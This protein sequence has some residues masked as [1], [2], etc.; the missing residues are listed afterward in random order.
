[1]VLDTARSAGSAIGEAVGLIKPKKARLV[2]V[3]DI[4][5]KDSDDIECMF[6]PTE[7]QL[8]QTTIVNWTPA[9]GKPG[10]TAEYGGTN[11][12]RL[13]VTLFFDAYDQLHGDIT[14]KITRLLSWTLPM[15]DTREDYKPTS[16][17]I[18]FVW[19]NK[20]LAD[21]CGYLTSVDVKYK[22][23]SKNGTPL[24]ADVTIA[25]EGAT[26]E[27]AGTN[28]TSH[29]TNSTKTHTVVEGESIQAVAFGKLGKPAYW[30]AIAD[31]N[32]IDDPFRLAPGTVLLIPSLADAAKG[33]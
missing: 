13:N 24:R 7:Y 23:F 25:L 27:F 3:S 6:N 17:L 19:G 15:E 12:L 26:P 31:L 8:T 30:R 11:P 32:G 10:G 2:V 9:P 1:M 20:Q 22:L 14:P 16:P 29:A 33:S 18:G 21:F 4:L 5:P 28:P